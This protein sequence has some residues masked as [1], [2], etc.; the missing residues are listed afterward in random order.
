MSEIVVT[1]GFEFRDSSRRE[2][3]RIEIPCWCFPEESRLVVV[4]GTAVENGREFNWIDCSVRGRGQ[5]DVG[6]PATHLIAAHNAT[7]ITQKGVFCQCFLDILSVT[8]RRP[9]PASV[10]LGPDGLRALLEFLQ[11]HECTSPDDE[12]AE[13]ACEGCGDDSRVC[14]CDWEPERCDEC[15]AYVDGCTCYGDFHA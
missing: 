13:H 3:A 6:R 1:E 5:G 9:Q 10:D 2:V 4:A 12:L 8:L 14:G 11:A 7:T 15:G